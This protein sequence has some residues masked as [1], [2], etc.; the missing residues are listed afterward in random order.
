MNGISRRVVLRAAGAALALP[1]LESLPLHASSH[2]GPREFPKRFAVL[3]MGNGINGNHWWARGSGAAMQL[4]RSLE[5][6]EPLKHKV[7]VINGLFNEPAVGT[8]IHPA[9]TGNLL[10][11]VPIRRGPIARSGITVYQLLASRIGQ[12]TPCASLV[13]SCERPMP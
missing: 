12:E 1:W 2:D 6:L 4:S 13:M 9:Q 8:G 3:I 11:G 10:S 5:P 7:N